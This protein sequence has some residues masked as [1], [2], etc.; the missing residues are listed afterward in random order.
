MRHVVNICAQ[1]FTCDS[2]GDIASQL[3]AL[4]D[5]GTLWGLSRGKW[6]LLPDIPQEAV[7]GGR[8]E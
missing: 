5:D 4:C 1:T 7:E 2:H 6:E 3:V 8:A